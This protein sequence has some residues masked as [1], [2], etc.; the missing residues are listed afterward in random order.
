MCNETFVR[1]ADTGQRPTEPA[2]RSRASNRTSAYQYRSSRGALDEGV[3]M[4]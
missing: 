3:N 1:L 2:G 4:R